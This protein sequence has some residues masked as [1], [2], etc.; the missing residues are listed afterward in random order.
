MRTTTGITI[1]EQVLSF[2]GSNNPVS[3][4]TF[5]SNVFKNNSIYSTTIT[6]QLTDAS[7]G[8]FTFSFSAD[9]VGSY[10]LWTKNLST[11][12]IFI[13][14]AIE[15]VSDDEISQTIYIGI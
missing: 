2:D 6:S 10:W 13:S 15:V 1:Y 3:G 14:D 8:M 5:N 11:N 4:A 12:T 9:T 7:S